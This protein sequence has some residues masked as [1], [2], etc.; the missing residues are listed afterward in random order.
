MKIRKYAKPITIVLLV[1]MLLTTVVGALAYA[2]GTGG[3][4]G[5]AESRAE[6]RG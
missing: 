4:A 1:V 5:V 6:S 2:D 3:S